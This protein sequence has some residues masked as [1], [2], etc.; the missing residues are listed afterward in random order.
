MFLKTILLPFV[1]F[2]KSF[3]CNHEY[4]L[5]RYAEYFRYIAEAV[6]PGVKVNDSLLFHPVKFL[7]LRCHIIDYTAVNS[8]VKS[9]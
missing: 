6:P 5:S 2:V 8:F 1:F 3:F 9:F 7:F 4:P